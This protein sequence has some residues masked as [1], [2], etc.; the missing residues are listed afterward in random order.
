MLTSSSSYVAS[1][2]ERDLRTKLDNDEVV[3]TILL[4]DQSMKEG[5]HVVDNSKTQTGRSPPPSSAT[6]Q[7][8]KSRAK[9][10]LQLVLCATAHLVGG[11]CKQ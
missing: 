8:I 3:R 1:D 9:S 2:I 7:S 5:N 6:I 11:C 10:F 4:E